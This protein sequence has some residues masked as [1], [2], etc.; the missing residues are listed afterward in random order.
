MPPLAISLSGINWDSIF[1]ED[2]T[3]WD[4]DWDSIFLAEISGAGEHYLPQ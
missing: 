1:G 2:V 3:E 4:P